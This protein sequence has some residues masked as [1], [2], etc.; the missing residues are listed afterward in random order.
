MMLTM[1]PNNAPFDLPNRLHDGL[2]DEQGAIT[3]F[4]PKAPSILTSSRSPRFILVCA[5]MAFDRN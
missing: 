1:V 5:L 2:I 3:E 4:G